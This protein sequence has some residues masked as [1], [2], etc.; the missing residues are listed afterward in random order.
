VTDA[1]RGAAPW[2]RLS[3]VAAVILGALCGALA[4]DVAATADHGVVYL[5]R[6]E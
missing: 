4:V 3:L 6:A 2:A 1:G 5:A